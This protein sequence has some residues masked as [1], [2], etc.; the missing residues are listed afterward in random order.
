MAK[1]SPKRGDLARVAKAVVDEATA[2]RP[3]RKR[4]WVITPDGEPQQKIIL[5]HHPWETL[6]VTDD[7]PKTEVHISE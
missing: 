5:R 2:E 6:P 4:G 7:Q 1:K 3:E